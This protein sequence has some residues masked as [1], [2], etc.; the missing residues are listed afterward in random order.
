VGSLEMTGGAD[1]RITSPSTS[2]PGQNPGVGIFTA[3]AWQDF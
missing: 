2:V 3:I 1:L